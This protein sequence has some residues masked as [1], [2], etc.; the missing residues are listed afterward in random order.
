MGASR[1][2]R[3]SLLM[4]HA[5]GTTLPQM[6]LPRTH[7]RHDSLRIVG[8][9]GGDEADKLNILWGTQSRKIYRGDGSLV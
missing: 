1:S 8:C 3:L 6:E 4:N 9:G 2:A 5:P 7:N